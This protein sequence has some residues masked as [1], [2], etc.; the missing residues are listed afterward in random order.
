VIDLRIDPD[1]ITTRATMSQ[2]RAAALARQ[3]GGPS[4]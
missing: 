3:G 2:I 4:K 1:M